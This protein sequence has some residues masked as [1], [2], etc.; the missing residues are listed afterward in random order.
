MVFSVITLSIEKIIPEQ[1]I[2]QGAI[3]GNQLNHVIMGELLS[4][5]RNADLVGILTK[6]VIAVLLPMTSNGNAKIAMSRLLKCL[7]SKSFTINNIVLSLKFV[8]VVTSFDA[9]ETPDLTSFIRFAE[10]GH[11]DF[12]NRLRNVQDLYYE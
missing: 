5:L 10:N 1:P 7:N 3:D 12:L 8:G 6:K 9:E 4:L 11:D 2:P